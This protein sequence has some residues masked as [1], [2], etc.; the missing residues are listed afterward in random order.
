MR[1]DSNFSQGYINN[2]VGPVIRS[3]EIA[4]AVIE[5]AEE[6]NPGKEI[7]VKDELAYVRIDTD[8]EMII[9]RETIQRALGR[10]FEIQEIEINMACFAGR[11]ENTT[12]YIRFYFEKK[13]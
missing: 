8:D 5:A 3:G 10:S 11:I 9:R 7:S 4:Q 12:D 13:L 1:D 6:D 2:R